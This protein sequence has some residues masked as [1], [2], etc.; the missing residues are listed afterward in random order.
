MLRPKRT[1][2]RLL[3]GL[4]RPGKIEGL[5]FGVREP[6]SQERPHRAALLVHIGDATGSA[7][8]NVAQEIDG[9]PRSVLLRQTGEASPDRGMVVHRI[10]GLRRG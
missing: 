3:A 8:G 5:D 4:V 1:A 10:S 7:H 2:S 6:A 9:R